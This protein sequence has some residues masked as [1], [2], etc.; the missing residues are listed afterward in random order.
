MGTHQF[1][2][3][4]ID[5]IHASG[6]FDDFKPDSSLPEF[7]RINVIFGSNG[8]GKTS[9][10]RAFDRATQD[11][12]RQ[13]NV[14]LS[15]DDGQGRRS[16]NGHADGIFN[17]IHVFSDE[18]V[19][20][21]QNFSG[22]EP[23]MDAILTIGERSVDAD[24][25]LAGLQGSLKGLIAD[26]DRCEEALKDAEKNYQASLATISRAVVDDLTKLG[27]R[28]QSRS[29]YSTAIVE[30]R[31]NETKTERKTLSPEKLSDERQLIAAGRQGELTALESESKVREGLASEAAELLGA[32]PSTII[33]D[34]LGRHPGATSWVQQGRHLHDGVEECI[35]C[36]S[37]LTASR[38][39]EIDQH[40]SGEVAKVESKIGS[41]IEDLKRL[42]A[43]FDR[44]LTEVPSKS[45]VYPD[46][47]HVFEVADGLYRDQMSEL[48]SWAEEIE[49]R[50]AGKQGNVLQVPTDTTVSEPK[51]ADATHLN[52]AIVKHNERS[53]AHDAMVQ[54]AA[55][56]IEMHHLDAGGASADQFLKDQADAKTKLES[57]VLAL[58]DARKQIA[59]LE[60]VEGDPNPSATVLNQEV[61]RLLG[62]SDLKFEAAGPRYRA[63]RNGEPAVDLSEGERTAISLVHFMEVV[64]RRD[65]SGGKS[66]VI[67]DDPVSSLDQNIFMG[68]STY[69]WSECL[70]KEHVEQLFLLT[71]NFELFRQW[72]LQLEMLPE[73]LRR[74]LPSETYEMRCRHETIS[75]TTRRRPILTAWPP[76]ASARKKVRSTYHHS[77]MAIVEAKARLDRD[78]SL[79]D[80]LDAQLL[81]PNVM[82]RMLETFLGFKRPEWAGD[83]H[84]AMRSSTKLLQD[85]GYEGDADALRSKLTRYTNAFS[86]DESPDTTSVIN[87]E[88]VGPAIAAI[89]EF[90]RY[91]DQ[92]HFDGLC[93]VVGADPE[94]LVLVVE[95]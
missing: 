46:L 31:L 63:L 57:A 58:A 93:K 90:M 76:T 44:S 24:K 22:A 54:A 92:D 38:K 85:A 48:R 81:F 69:I 7:G 5:W 72:D 65:P 78:G 14:S 15:L 18:F 94:Q 66:I 49:E 36:G 47:R 26:R 62:H 51:V 16:T 80:R 23:E 68:V 33:L 8:S 2:I 35:F 52:E 11:V 74:S 73:H 70:V 39:T 27:G 30:R 87:P 29:H 40:F 28:F 12:A 86:H 19:E 21:S 84:R 67:I 59:S 91:L 95:S 55:S 25:R 32:S 37:A 89:F 45:D 43:K 42:R 9:M 88:E 13:S 64:A 61:A 71:H 79:D 77:F 83:L 1:M 50:L 10:A 41:L 20:R 3:R 6:L 4:R 17:R 75:G 82:R 56:R 60:T 53:R 34:T